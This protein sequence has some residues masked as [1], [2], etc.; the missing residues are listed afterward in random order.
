MSYS[1]D[2][3]NHKTRVQRL[4]EALY[5][6]GVYVRLDIWDVRP[7]EQFPLFM[8]ESLDRCDYILVVCTPA[9]KQKADKGTGGAGY[10]TSVV[11]ADIL[12]GKRDRVQ[13]VPVL[14]SGTPEDALPNY[15]KGAYYVDMRQPSDF[16]FGVAELL[17]HF[18]KRPAYARPE[19]K[20]PVS[21]PPNVQA[22][23]QRE[24]M[25][26]QTSN[27][28]EKTRL[29]E[30]A[31]EL[32]RPAYYHRQAAWAALRGGEIETARMHDLRAVEIDPKCVH[33]WVG[34]VVEAGALQDRELLERAFSTVKKLDLIEA[35][36]TE[37]TEDK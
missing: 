3:E 30:R 19:L 14:C 37:K 2:S 23:R 33:A 9:Y 15:L 28:H 12:S 11:S 8:N 7:G 10:E 24:S 35:K 21:G 26:Q 22:A 13:V 27:W 36:R 1:H 31:A 4:A 18:H 6:G 34:L 5:Q 25:A 29:Y 16:A 32:D 17:E 20:N